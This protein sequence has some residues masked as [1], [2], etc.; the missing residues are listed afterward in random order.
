MTVKP[1]SEN[2][3]V[4]QLKIVDQEN[5]PRESTEVVTSVTI[6]TGAHKQ[7]FEVPNIAI[8][9]DSDN[10]EPKERNLAS[11]SSQ[12]SVDVENIFGRHK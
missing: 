9:T 8:I 4:V 3:T 2:D 5:A 1:S 12:E 6:D 7:P 11:P 10:D